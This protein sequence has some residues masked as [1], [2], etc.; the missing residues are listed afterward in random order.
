MSNNKLLDCPKSSEIILEKL[1]ATFDKRYYDKY[2]NFTIGDLEYICISRGKFNDKGKW[3]INIIPIP[4]QTN[5]ILEDY[6]K[7][8]PSRYKSKCL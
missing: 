1:T 2:D 5:L 3:I 4:Y 6:T 8:L 7:G